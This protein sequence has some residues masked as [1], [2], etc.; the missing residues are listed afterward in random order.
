MQQD[1]GY[2]CKVKRSA[3]TCRMGGEMP[4]GQ[5][6]ER[7]LCQNQLPLVIS[8]SV[9]WVI[10]LK[11]S[12]F[13][14]GELLFTSLVLRLFLQPHCSTRHQISVGAEQKVQNIYFVGWRRLL[15]SPRRLFDIIFCRCLIGVGIFAETL[16]CVCG[17]PV[18][19]VKWAAT[20]NLS[21]YLSHVLPASLAA[22]LLSLSNTAARLCDAVR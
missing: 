9:C 11:R 10:G 20:S 13:P 19:C 15:S 18:I 7:Q 2:L 22:P 21:S 5:W 14:V 12:Y 16:H 4:I 1:H 17:L 8:E 3:D 6:A